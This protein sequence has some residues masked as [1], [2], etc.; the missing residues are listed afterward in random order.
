MLKYPCSYWRMERSHYLQFAVN[1]AFREQF[2]VKSFMGIFINTPF[3]NI[4]FA[5]DA[6]FCMFCISVKKNNNNKPWNSYLMNF[7]WI[8]FISYF[9]TSKAD[10][11]DVLIFKRVH[12]N[13]ESAILLKVGVNGNELRKYE[14]VCL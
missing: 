13:I 10:I 9:K 5:S 14:I 11:A 12:I 2:K 7:L 4:F 1:A 3:Q 6:L 8:V